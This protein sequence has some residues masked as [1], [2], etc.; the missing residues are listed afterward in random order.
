MSSGPFDLAAGDTTTFSF[1]IVMGDD[2]SDVRFN[3][4]TAQF[5]Y[6][7]NYLGAD[8]P[9]PPTVC[10]VAGDG[11]VTLYWDRAAEESIDIMTGYR[12]V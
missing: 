10:A 11:Q 8:P 3:A 12:E 6:E 5:M 9:K 7:L 2:T 1:A 4:R